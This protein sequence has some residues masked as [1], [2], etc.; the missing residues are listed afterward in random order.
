M[1]FAIIISSVYKTSKPTCKVGLKGVHFTKSVYY[2]WSVQL[3]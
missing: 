3:T 1:D 2:K